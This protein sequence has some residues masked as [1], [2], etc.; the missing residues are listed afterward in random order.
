MAVISAVF[1]KSLWAKTKGLLGARQAYPVFFKTRW[2]IHTFCLNFP[3]DVLILDSRS[4]VVNMAQRLPPYRI[5]FWHPRHEHVLE[6]P[7][8]EIAKLAIRR[9]DTV[10]VECINLPHKR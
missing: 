1:Q 10:E 5:F 6:L 3:I 7:A 9:G 4:K 8:G 2:G